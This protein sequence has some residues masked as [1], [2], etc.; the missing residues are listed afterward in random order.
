[1]SID[2]TAASATRRA[3][4][5]LR[6]PGADVRVS[7]RRYR[8][9]YLADVVLQRLSDGRRLVVVR[10]GDR[11]PAHVRQR[12]ERWPVSFGVVEPRRVEGR[13]VLS[14]GYEGS[15]AYGTARDAAECLVVQRVEGPGSRQRFS[16]E[17]SRRRSAGR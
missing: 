5:T 9:A 3:W 12:Q 7:G 14:W 10:S 8:P 11:L 1:M 6:A 17:K 15:G 13:R 4:H 2:A 16:I